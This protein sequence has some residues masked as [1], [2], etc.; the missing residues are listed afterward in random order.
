MS[1]QPTFDTHLTSAIPPWSML[2]VIPDG[3]SALSFV[4]AP[5]GFALCIIQGKKCGQVSDLLTEFARALDFPD[6]FGH[7]WDALEECLADFDWL[8][9]K[10]YILLITDAH[11]VLPDDEDEY[12]TLLEVLSDAGEAWSKGQTADGRRAPF[13]GVFVVP[14]Q[15]KSKRKRWELEEFFLDKRK[16]PR[17]KPARK[18]SA[19]T[20]K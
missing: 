2:L 12:D 14:E 3:D 1:L 9:A 5:P 19:K 17:A 13:H 15:D 16:P 7:N 11:A 4:K 6:Y 10:G 20:S 18:R 8:P